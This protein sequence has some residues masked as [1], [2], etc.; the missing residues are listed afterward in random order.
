MKDRC[1]NEHNK[2]YKD[3]GGRGIKICDDWLNNN[4]LFFNWSMENGYTDNLTIDRI[5]VNGNYE[6]SNCRWI[7]KKQQNR[8]SR[9]NVNFTYNNETH[10]LS[11]WCEVL[12]LNYGTVLSRINKLNWSIYKALELL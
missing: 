3:Y 11:E 8:N 2:Q 4:T 7:T 1:Y 5:N 12:G 9:K 10:C 6:P